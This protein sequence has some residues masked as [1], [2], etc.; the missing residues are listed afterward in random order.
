[1]AKVAMI[2]IA[3]CW[4]WT[5]AHQPTTGY[6]RFGITSG[7]VEYAHRAAWRLLVGPIPAGLHVCHHCDVRLCV[8]PEHLFVGT[9][10]ENMQDAS[11][12]GRV[13]LP[14]ATWCSSELHQ[15]AKLTDA[16]VLEIRACSTSSAV[17]AKDLGV[18]PSTVWAART[19]RT[20]KDVA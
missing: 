9:R 18:T 2:P 13:V 3:G 14:E 5:A 12:K 4:I 11:R 19:R 20:F 10:A 6:G 8:N 7:E 15:V 16:Q 1:M 17:L